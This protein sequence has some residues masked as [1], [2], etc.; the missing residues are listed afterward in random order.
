MYIERESYPRYVDIDI[1]IY[2]YGALRGAIADITA[3]MQCRFVIYIYIGV[4]AYR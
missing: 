1:N 2:I 3:L 4:S